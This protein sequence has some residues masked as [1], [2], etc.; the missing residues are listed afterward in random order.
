MT[1][2]WSYGGSL[3]A[4][5]GPDPYWSNQSVN[6]WLSRLLPPGGP[7]TALMVLLCAAL[8]AL[9]VGV[10]AR[11]RRGWPGAYAILLCYSVVAAPKRV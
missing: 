7:E 1:G 9:A 8:G 3:V 2:R 4:M 10:A 6:G 11:Q 5:F